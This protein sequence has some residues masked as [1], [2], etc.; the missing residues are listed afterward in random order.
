M[1][2]QKQRFHPPAW[3]QVLEMVSHRIS[4]NEEIPGSGFLIHLP[5]SS[6]I[7]RKVTKVS[8]ASFTN[9][10]PDF[11][12]GSKRIGETIPLSI[13]KCFVFLNSSQ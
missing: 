12:G 11:T 8:A 1:C 13:S 2:A 7:A 10:R 6:V 3:R 5:S 4:A 9:H